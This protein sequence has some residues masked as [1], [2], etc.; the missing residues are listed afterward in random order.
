MIGII[1]AEHVTDGRNS[2][3]AYT[4]HPSRTTAAKMKELY[5]CTCSQGI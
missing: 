2:K 3:A 4:I 1:A 5:T